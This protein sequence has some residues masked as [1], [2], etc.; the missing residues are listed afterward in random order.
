MGKFKNASMTNGQWTETISGEWNSGKGRLEVT[1]GITESISTEGQ[2]EITGSGKGPSH[3]P[4][5]NYRC[6]SGDSGTKLFWFQNK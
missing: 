4:T 6:T 5:G 2:Y 1:K 3:P